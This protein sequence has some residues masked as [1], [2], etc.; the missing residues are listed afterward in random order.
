MKKKKKKIVRNHTERDLAYVGQEELGALE[1]DKIVRIN[2]EKNEEIC[3]HIR[4]KG[5]LE[6]RN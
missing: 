1:L 6:S 4:E 5:E 3:R 2:Q